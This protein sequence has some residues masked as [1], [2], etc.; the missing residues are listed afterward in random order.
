MTDRDDNAGADRSAAAGAALLE[1]TFALLER[2]TADR[3]SDFRTFAFATIEDG[4]PAVRMVVL[5]AVDRPKRGITFWTD[6]RSAKVAA[7]ERP[8]E[9]LF[10][11]PRTSI[12]LRLL[13]TVQARG[14]DE[15]DVA[16]L[17]DGLPDDAL[18]DYAT[19]SAPGSP[20][21][22]G[23]AFDRKR[24]R[25]NFTRVTLLPLSVDLLELSRGANRRFRVDFESGETVVPLTP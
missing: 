14:T 2:A 3:R 9:A 23:T 13:S 20:W 5:R 21:D 7:L 8:V 15:P 25:E 18:H 4:R 19:A 10:W 17:F 1:R 24:A 11:D 22:G 16:A 6:R 12:Q